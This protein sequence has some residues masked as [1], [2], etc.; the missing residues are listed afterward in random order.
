M[1]LFR[2]ESRPSA[3]GPAMALTPSTMLPL[4][5][6]LP[7]A[8]ML[9]RLTP[10]HGGVLEP[11]DLEGRPVL[12]MFLCPHCPFVKHIEPELSRLQ[13]DYGDRLAMV[14]ICSNSVRTHP[15]D[16]PEGMRAQATAH[17]WSFPYLAD[18]DQAVAREFRAACTPDLYLFD[19]AHRLAYRGQLDP[20]RPGND[21]P[22]DGRDLRAAME[23]VL[24]GRAPVGD[25]QPS[26]GCNIKW[27]PGSA[28]D[29]T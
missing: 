16:G 10:V 15:Q 20:S 25:Q 18:A 19:A 29:W 23:D 4:G 26:I 27:H 1:I 2:P 9:G 6:R 14:G 8:L 3:G 13:E 21:A 11:A 7:L 5:T 28:P 22:L 12:V 17:G 24:A